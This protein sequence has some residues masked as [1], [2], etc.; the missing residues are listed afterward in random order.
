MFDFSI[1]VYNLV[2]GNSTISF[3]NNV[4][5]KQR[6]YIIIRNKSVCLF[7]FFFPF[8]LTFSSHKLNIFVK[9]FYPFVLR[10]CV[11]LLLVSLTKGS[12]RIYDNQLNNGL[13]YL[14]VVS[15]PCVNNGP[16]I[17]DSFWLILFLLFFLPYR[18]TSEHFCC[19]LS[20]V[21]AA[22]YITFGSFFFFFLIFCRA[23]KYQL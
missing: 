22:Y 14:T 2:F 4:S 8:H 5:S 1:S 7:V 19:S 21:Y 17:L 15:S 10:S 16:Y 12:I 11:I 6:Q 3:E 18:F 20:I 9:F 13:V 23:W